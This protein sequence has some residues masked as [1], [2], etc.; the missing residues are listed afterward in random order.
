MKHLNC[1][2]ALTQHVWPA[3]QRYGLV[4]HV[5]GGLLV[6]LDEHA[7]IDVAAT[8][9]PTL[10]DFEKVMSLQLVT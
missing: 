7:T 9:T 2:F 10:M 3:G 5:D 8:S 4:S 1:T 6:S